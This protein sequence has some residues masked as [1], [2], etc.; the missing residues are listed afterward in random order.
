MTG[1]VASTPH[2]ILDY[3]WPAG[4]H[5]PVMLLGFRSMRRATRQIYADTAEHGATTEHTASV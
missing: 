2:V 1:L 5:W 4:N 3:Q